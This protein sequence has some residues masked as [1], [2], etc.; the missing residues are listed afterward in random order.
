MPIYEYKCEDCGTPIEIRHGA[1]EIP[2]IKCELCGG[3]MKKIFQPVGI[4]FKGSGFYKTDSRV[5]SGSREK[6]QVS[7]PNNKSSEKRNVS[8]KG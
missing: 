3:K 7:T 4:V 5:S 2:D 8:K 6:K 1:T